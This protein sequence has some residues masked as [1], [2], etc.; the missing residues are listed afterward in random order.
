[1]K[2]S[3]DSTGAGFYEAFS[4]IIFATMAIFVLLMTIFLVLAQES[5]PIRQAQKKLEALQEQVTE[6]KEKKEEIKNESTQLESRLEELSN[7]NVEIAIAVDKTGSME[8]E[9]YNLKNAIKQLAKILPKVM[10]KVS[11]SIAAYHLDENDRD[12]TAIFN[13]KQIY[14][15][16]KDNGASYKS[17]T[18]FL[19]RQRHKGGAAPVLSATNKVLAQFNSTANERDH[20]VFMLLGDVGPYEIT[21]NSPDV[22]TPRG[23]QRAASLVSNIKQWVRAK[24]NRNIILLFSGRDEINGKYDSTSARRNKH[25]K[26]MNLFKQIASESGQPKAYTENQSR[27]L[28]DFLVAAL[29]RK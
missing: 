29:K 23:E 18:N 28:V 11:I 14:D 9:L 2:L 3:D 20:Q 21:A 16:K 15:S 8:E 4:D 13:M 22:I 7:K 19:S 10:D 6:V 5:S 27:M 12:N 17:L 25:K 1:M 26:S 24:K